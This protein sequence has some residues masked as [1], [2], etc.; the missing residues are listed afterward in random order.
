MTFDELCEIVEAA[1]QQ[2][3]LMRDSKA[4]WEKRTAEI[5]KL[6]P[7]VVWR[8]PIREHKRET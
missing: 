3:Y 6:H 4:E 1:D 5:R 8:E 7:G 2:S